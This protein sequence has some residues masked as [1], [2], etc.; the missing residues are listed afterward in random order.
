MGEI[1]V[2][3]WG[4]SRQAKHLACPDTAENAL[5]GL[6][7]SKADDCADLVFSFKSLVLNGIFS[8]LFAGCIFHLGS[9][10]DW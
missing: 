8:A 1:V 5:W 10:R 7:F 2:I 4:Y 9:G 3:F 6:R